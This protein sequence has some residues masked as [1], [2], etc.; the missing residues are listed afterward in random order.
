[1]TRPQDEAEAW[2]QALSERG[3]PALSL[4]L[5]DTAQPTGEATLAEL[6]RAREQWREWDALMFVSAAAVRHF[7][8]TAPAASPLPVSAT[9]FWAP[10]P[11]TA[12]A[13][14]RALAPLGVSPTQIDVPPDDAE[15]FDSEHLWPLVA[16]QVVSGHRLLVVR[17][18]SPAVSGSPRSTTGLAGQGRDWLI[19][20]CR[21]QGGYAEA[22]VAYE[23]RA[24]VWSAER[25]AQAADGAAQGSLWVFSSSEAVQ[26]LREALP[27]Q[28]W[29]RAT[30]LCT[31]PRIAAAARAAGF[32]HVLL[33]RPALADVLRSLESA[34]P[35]P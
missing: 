22:C 2:V 30:A 26:H 11:G 4:P 19:Q 17:G 5:I 1:V 23:R 34:Q 29:S 16:H 15:Q 14:A 3:W 9:R 12:R 28:D 13:L 25:R 18:N 32:V 27:A 21:E 6:N 35:T 33:S 7:F 31:H 10:G 20:R 24:P 8:A